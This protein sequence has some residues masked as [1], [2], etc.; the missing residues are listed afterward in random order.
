MLAK[1]YGN[2]AIA[3]SISAAGQATRLSTIEEQLA[4]CANG[5]MCGNCI[6][7]KKLSE[8]A[9]RLATRVA[10]RPE[11]FGHLQCLIAA[12]L[13]LNQSEEMGLTPL[14]VAGWEGLPMQ[15]DYLLS[16]DP[17]LDYRNG[18]GGDALGTVIHGAEHCPNAEGRDHIVCARLLLEAGAKL[19]QPEVDGCGSEPMTLFL[20]EWLDHQGTALEA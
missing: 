15:V 20:E 3:N 2:D 4:R 6:D 14:H 8:E 7:P 1:I 18:F 10:A 11:R 13:D 12:G 16:L 17:D 5:L 19:R 9:K